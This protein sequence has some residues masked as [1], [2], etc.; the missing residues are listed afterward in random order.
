MDPEFS[1]RYRE[2]YDKHWWWRAREELILEILRREQ[3][4]GGWG[5][6]LDVGCGDGLFFR[7]LQQ[8]GKVEGIEP[9]AEIIHPDNPFRQQIHIGSFDENFQPG[10]KYSLILM[11]DVLEHLDSP[12]AALQHALS[13]L[14][15]NGSLLITVPAFRLLWTSHDQL[16][17][18]HTR[19]T[20]SSFAKIAKKAQM[21]IAHAR[22]L[23]FWLF[24]AKLA[25][26]AKESLLGSK[27]SIPKVPS[28]GLNHLLYLA[29]R[30]EEKLLGTLPIPIGGSLLVLG[31]ADSSIVPPSRNNPA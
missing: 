13:L 23:F 7:Q 5:N 21:K 6:I 18:H 17:H 3:P 31:H 8:F 22:Y 16:N 24:L 25:V 27:P 12:V 15:P 11:L 14:Q 4:P 28:P 10:K 26:R 20:K 1:Q 19:Y 9:V 30:A 29:S 2:I